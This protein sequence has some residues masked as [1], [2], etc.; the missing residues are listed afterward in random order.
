MLDICRKHVECLLTVQSCVHYCPLL[1]STFE[2]SKALCSLPL[3]LPGRFEFERDF[4]WCV[5]LLANLNQPSL[6]IVHIHSRKVQRFILD[7]QEWGRRSGM[8]AAV[9]PRG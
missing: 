6:I 4:A 5:C 2:H 8:R 7:R 9:G 3:F 1:Y